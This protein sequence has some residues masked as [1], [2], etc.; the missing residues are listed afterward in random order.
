MNILIFINIKFSFV[1]LHKLNLNNM[2]FLLQI[3]RT[4]KLVFFTFSVLFSFNSYSQV[5]YTQLGQ[6]I[7][8]DSSTDEMGR[9]V[10]LSSNG[11]VMVVGAP[12]NDFNGSNSGLVKVF[13]YNALNMLWEQKGTNLLGE[14]SDNLFGFCVSINSD[15][16]VI[17]VSAI[18]N[19]DSGFLS[20]HVRIFNWNGIDWIQKGND[21]N[22]LASGDYSGMSICL[23]NDGNVV[24][25][26]S[27]GYDGI[28][29]NS[30]QARVF[31]WH[32]PTSDWIQRGSDIN[33]EGAS[34]SSGRSVSL[35]STGNVLSIGAPNNNGTGLNSGHVRVY[36]WNTMDWVQVGNDI[37]GESSNDYSGFS[38]SLSDDGSILAI[39]AYGNTG[40]ATS[41][42]QARVFSW[43]GT[44][45]VQLGSDIDGEAAN[46]YFGKSVSLNSD[47]NIL[48]VGAPINNGSGLESGHVRIFYFDGI[49]WTQQGNEINGESSNDWS[50][51]FVSLSKDG[52]TVAIGAYGNDDAAF[53]AGHVRV[54]SING[55]VGVSKYDM[56]INN[57]VFPNPAQNEININGVESG[58]VMELMDLTGKVMVSQKVVGNNTIISTEN[59]SNGIYFVR[60]ENKGVVSTQK[61]II[62]K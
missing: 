62:S 20:G 39:G 32:E 55:I 48:A 11:R 44:D 43:N 21:I 19:S 38:T 42:G 29:S 34:N 15:G 16:N 61:V 26:G 54:F 17:A 47:G 58:S 8:G 4:F 25:I 28:G 7:D 12:N 35:N 14:T 33:G 60:I 40:A 50:G 2:K 24:A 36:Y 41:S 27:P 59:I 46:D 1:F 5:I 10:Q 52:M 53:D 3:T 31:S 22:G 51:D 56:F 49:N 18:N 37:D 23:N 6:D 30:G 13:T 9:S 45:W 57:E